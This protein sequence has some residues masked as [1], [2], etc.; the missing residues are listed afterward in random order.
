MTRLDQT[1]AELDDLVT[2]HLSIPVRE[3][4]SSPSFWLVDILFLLPGNSRAA[5]PPLTFD[6]VWITVWA[7]PQDRD[8]LKKAGFTI[9]P[10]VNR[11]EN[12]GTASINAEFHNA[13]L[14]LMW[15]EPAGPAVRDA[16]PAVEN[17]PHRVEWRSNGRHPE[18]FPIDADSEILS[19]PDAAQGSSV[20]G[21]RA[22]AVTDVKGARGLVPTF[23]H[24]LG[25]KRVTGVRLFAPPASRP[26]EPLEYLERSGV[27]GLRTGMGWVVEITFD[28]GVKGS[29]KDLRPEVPIVVKY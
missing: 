17:Y 8:A 16:R 24:P 26:A 9:S 28:G 15:S 18:W 20:V 19:T 27:V 6:D 25:V 11:D 21:P 3:R 13:F 7:A 5:A 23:V 29:T 2:K 12:R 22:L 4:S 10:R 1:I 14:E